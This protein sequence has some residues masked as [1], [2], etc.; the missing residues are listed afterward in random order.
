[1]NRLLSNISAEE[2]T[3]HGVLGGL[4]SFEVFGG[5]SIESCD[6][7]PPSELFDHIAPQVDIMTSSRKIAMSFRKGIGS[8]FKS[9]VHI[10]PLHRI[11]I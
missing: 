9:R 4:D 2:S 7:L 11:V 1:M 3:T 5:M 6:F 10:D 8:R